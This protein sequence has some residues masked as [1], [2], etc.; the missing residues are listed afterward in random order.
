M[1]GQLKPPI[2]LLGNT[3]SGT[4]I[5]QKLVATHPDVAGWYEPRTLWL[6]ADPGRPH[7]EFDAS[8]ASHRV[9][10]YIRKRFLEFQQESGNRVV[11]EKTPANIL[12]IPYVHE[13]FPEAT[14]L[15]IVRNPFSFISSVES[16]WRFRPIGKKG[17]RR[18]LKSTPVTQ[19]HHYAGRYVRD[20]LLRKVLKRERLSLWGPRY[21]GI[22]QDLRTRDLLTVVAR[23]WAVCS[24]KAERD[25]ALLGKDRVL[26]LR[27][28]DFVADPVSHLERICAHS[29]LQMTHDMV[30]AAHESVDRG[31][32]HKW[33]RFDPRDL[34]RVLPEIEDEMQRHGYDLPAE[35]GRRA[36]GAPPDGPAQVLGET[37]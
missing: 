36:A 27:Y 16:K 34:S 22:Q 11:M 25:L 32:Q 2:I 18:R 4:T 37:G 29:G 13:I 33:R 10:R 17:T 23:Q 21:E 5:V 35:I 3:R 30:K 12:K 9:K 1:S 14:Y 19:W 26:R 8:D 7:D 6:Y 28:E 31:R 20:K 24:R 15:F